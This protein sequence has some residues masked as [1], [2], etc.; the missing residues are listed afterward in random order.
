MK[1]ILTFA[2]MERRFAN[3][4][5]LVSDIET[6]AALR[7]RRGRVAWHSPDRDEVYRK[8]VEIKPRR[9]AVLYTGKM[10]E[11]TAIVL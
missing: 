4:W 9:F 5:L 10:P 3:E 6:D 7:V 1:E 11:K 8:A 2:Q